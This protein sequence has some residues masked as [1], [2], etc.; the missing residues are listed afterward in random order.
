MAGV[1]GNQIEAAI[2]GTATADWDTN[3]INA[4]LVDT[5]YTFGKEEANMSS[6]T[7]YQVDTDETITASAAVASAGTITCDASNPTF[8]A[9]A[10]GDTVNAVVV[11]SYATGGDANC[12]PWSYNDF[13]NLATNGSDILVTFHTSNGCFQITY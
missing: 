7:A 13:T 10:G 2:N 12:R 4:R 11:Y 3:T 5:S 6:T 9:V 8:G 1:Y